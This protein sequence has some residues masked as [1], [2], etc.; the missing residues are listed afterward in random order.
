M[1][2]YV[3]SDIHGFY[4]EMMDALLG[5]GYAKDPDAMLIVLGDCWD[6]GPDPYKVYLFLRE[7]IRQRKAIMV[8]GNH[9]YIMRQRMR[10]GYSEFIDIYNGT[11]GTLVSL[12]ES[13]MTRDEILGWIN[14]KFWKNYAEIGDYIFVH[15]WV[16]LYGFN[17][18]QHEE[19][20]SYKPFSIYPNWR[21]CKD[22]SVWE[23]AAWE[24]G[25]RAYKAGLTIPGKT[26][27][28]GH[29]H[30]SEFHHE[31]DEPQ[32]SEFGDDADFSVFLGKGCVAIDACTAH[33][34]KANVLVLDIPDKGKRR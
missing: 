28:C 34:G 14:G 6:R 8:I 20:E 12:M 9:E 1:R 26:I 30:T 25:F 16:P 7:K 10:R 18:Y 32:R 21:R 11:D 17:I 15:G 13:H 29:W 3:I 2:Y 33:S 22:K 19:L 31:F 23:N 24:S 5:A 27:V 4:Q